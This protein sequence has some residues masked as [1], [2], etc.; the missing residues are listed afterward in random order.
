VDARHPLGVLDG[1]AVG[2]HGPDVAAVGAESL[3][4]EHLGHQLGPELGDP[5]GAASTR[6]RVAEPVARQG[7]DYH[8]EGVGRVAAVAGRVGQQGH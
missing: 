1:Q 4:A 7:G 5:V 8:V 2:D 3:I 6:Q